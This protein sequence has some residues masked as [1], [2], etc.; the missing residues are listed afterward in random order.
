MRHDPPATQALRAVLARA[1]ALQT[2]GAWSEAAASYGQ[3]LALDPE[4]ADIANN[5]GVALWRQDRLD[6]AAAAFCRALQLRPALAEA[7]NNLGTALRDS[8]RPQ[9]AEECFRTAVALRPDYALAHNNLGMTLLGRGEFAS[10]WAEYEWRWKIPGLSKPG[11]R[12]GLAQWRGE[13]A[14]GRRLLIHSEQG[15]GDTLQFCRYAPLAADRGLDVTLVVPPVL[16]RLLRSLR[17]VTSVVAPDDGL[18]A[19]GL[20]CP[21]LSLPLAVGTTL[22][23]IPAAVPYL[24]ARGADMATWAMRLDAMAGPALRVGV[25]WAGNTSLAADRRRSMS[26]DYLAGLAALEG[27]RLV[28]L[29]KGGPAPPSGLPMIDWMHLVRD[30]ADTAGLIANLDLIIAVDSAPAHLAAAM[31]KPVWLLDRF[32]SCWRWL[33]GRTDSPWYPT[34]RI[35]RQRQPGD[36]VGV[37]ARVAQDLH[38]LAAP[39]IRAGRRR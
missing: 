39:V 4:N 11:E 3:A 1:A 30:F 5:L 2:A 10:G 17:G 14:P 6:E 16:V 36:W 22:A 38:Q 24:H 23:T 9:E 34:L 21:M 13:A 33:S 26:P 31:G 20:V 29:Q 35:Y 8:G 32:D 7:H 28:S 15:L 18:P 12:F 19:S 25:A 37:L 27:V